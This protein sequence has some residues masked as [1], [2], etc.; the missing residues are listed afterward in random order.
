M[1]IMNPSPTQHINSNTYVF[2]TP[3]K[4][5]QNNFMLWKSQVVSNIRANELE[6]FIDG[7]H[8]CPPRR[9][10]NPGLNQTII[11][12][13][14]PEYQFGRNRTT[15]FWAGCSHHSVKVSL[16]LWWIVLLHM[17]FGQLLPINMVQE[18]G[19]EFYTWEHRF[20]PPKRDLLQFMIIIPEWKPS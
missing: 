11:T 12:T 14:N 19:L 3:V 2:T 10:T 6:G 7:S 18:Q 20:K 5:I 17:K 16:A 13:R 8:T 15:F 1:T 4:L 9:F